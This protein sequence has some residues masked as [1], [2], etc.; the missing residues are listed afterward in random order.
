MQIPTGGCSCIGTLGAYLGGGYGLLAGLH[1]LGIDNLLSLNMVLPDG[2]ARTVTPKDTDLWWAVRGAGPNFGTV[3]SAVVKSYPVAPAQQMAFQGPLFFAPE[4][5]E[6][7]VS[8]IDKLNVTPKMALLMYYVTSGPPA[9]TPTVFVNVFYYGSAAEGKEAFRS[10]FAV[11]PVQDLTAMVRY[12]HWNDG[13]AGFCTKGGRKPS[14]GAAHTRMVPA[15]WR[16]VWDAYVA[17]LRNN[18][19]GNSAIVMEDYSPAGVMAAGDASASFAL[20][21]FQYNSIAIPWYDDKALDQKANAFGARVRAL[22]Q[23]SDGVPGN[24]S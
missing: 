21:R 2:S 6:A 18:G 13:A 3:T 24:F 16:A 20:R 5:I 23:A 10:I 19:T 9:F 7:L 8:A 14:Y 12:D 4:K 22:L 15:T 11:G 17:W 1:G